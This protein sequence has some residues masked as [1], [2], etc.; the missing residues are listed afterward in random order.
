MYPQD[1]KINI[2]HFPFQGRTAKEG[3]FQAFSETRVYKVECVIR[4]GN[5]AD[6]TTA[7]VNLT[8][9]LN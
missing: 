6:I 9:L 7:I 2:Q 3:I 5:S 4:C 1:L 8:P